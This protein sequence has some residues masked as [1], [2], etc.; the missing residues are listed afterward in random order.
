MTSLASKGSA[1]GGTHQLCAHCSL[2]VPPAR[3]VESGDAFCCAGCEAVYAI[4]H[5]SDLDEY[6]AMRDRLG[7]EKTGP[8]RVSGK[9]FD[10]FDDPEFLKRYAEPRSEGLL[11]VRFYLEG[12]LRGLFVAGRESSVGT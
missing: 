8:A 11:S 12:A 7:A 10:Y 3:Q 4:L 6:Y 2:P 9:A 5:E 1:K